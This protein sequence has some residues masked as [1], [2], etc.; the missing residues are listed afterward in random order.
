VS[1][2]LLLFLGSQLAFALLGG[3]LDRSIGRKVAHK[4]ISTSE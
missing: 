4:R 3:W 2:A 1:F